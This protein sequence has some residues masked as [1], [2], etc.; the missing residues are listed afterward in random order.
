[1]S[2][3][4]NIRELALSTFGGGGRMRRHKYR[5]MA[6]NANIYEIVYDDGELVRVMNVRGTYQSAT[7]LEKDCYELVFGYHRAYNAMFKARPVMAG[8]GED[9]ASAW[10]AVRPE[11]SVELPAVHFR[12]PSDAAS[13]E[14]SGGEAPAIRK[15][16]MLGG[17]G[18]SYPKYLIAH[19]PEVSVDV[20]EVD[21]M[22]VSIAQRWFYLDRLMAEFETEETGRL[23]I[24][25]Q[26]ARE[27]LEEPG[28]RYDA[29]VNDCFSARV[30]V[31]SLAT[32]EA[33]HV[34]HSRLSEGGLFLTNVISALRGPHAQ[35]LHRVM[36]T[37]QQEFAHV[38]VIPG[39]EG[40]PRM[41]DNYVVIATDGTYAFDHEI[42]VQPDPETKILVDAY[43]DDYEDEF[44]LVDT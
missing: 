32:R 40:L 27:F 17:G 43:I 16:A 1:M 8:A 37:L 38:Y 21:P 19:H 25:V 13:P 9:D 33:V 26:D 30:P 3:F 11:D 7:Y 10:K 31:M 22:V 24:Y 14:G 42:N 20:V 39:S 4:T 29:I 35:L 28:A 15:V 44:F 5:T 41:V 23:G 34:I 6:G 18:F 12:K 2:I 36:F